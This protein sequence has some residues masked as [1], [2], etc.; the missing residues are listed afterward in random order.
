MIY[1]TKNK[2][3]I[4]LPS[5]DEI[6]QKDDKILF[7]CDDYASNE[8]EYIAQN[9]YELHYILTGEEKSKLKIKGYK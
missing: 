7:A 5:C 4:L 2:R 1:N 3:E 9:I 6:L 8:I